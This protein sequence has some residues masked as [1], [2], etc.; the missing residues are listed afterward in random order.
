MENYQIKKFS[1]MKRHNS[2]MILKLGL[3]FSV[4]AVIGSSCVKSRPGA[5]D[6]SNL[7]PT[8]LIPEGGLQ[9]FSTQALLFPGTDSVD[10]ATFHLNY[11]AT[12]VA[13][14]DE[15]ISYA[16]DPVALAAYNAT[17][18]DV[19]DTFAVMPD[20]IFS[21]KDGSGTVAKGQNYS[22]AIPFTVYPD[23]IN[24]KK[25]YM[26]PV[27]ITTAPSGTQKTANF[28]TIYYH[29]IGNPI[30]GAYTNLW[31]RWNDPDK[32]PATP[33]VTATGPELFAPIDGTTIS[34]P[35]IGTGIVYILTFDD[36]GNGNLSNFA[37][38]LDPAS[39]KSAGITAG[40]PTIIKADPVLGVYMFQFTYL[41]GSGAGRTIQDTYTK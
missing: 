33:D 37:V 4:L 32:P 5:T 24:P 18:S 8:V 28:N 38:S 25:N 14:V 20:S 9:N 7:S 3:L 21:F 23:K 11:A 17:I 27:T 19:K 31:N 41:N 35:D 6:F 34:V 36:D 13:P 40:T 15:T 30:A 39:V 2:N 16:F 10:T 22:P 12:S 29:L 1:G 26:Y